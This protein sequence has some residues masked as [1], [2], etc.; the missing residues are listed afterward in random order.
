MNNNKIINEN[1]FDNIIF[2]MAENSI[3]QMCKNAN[4]DISNYDFEFRIINNLEEMERNGEF[5][6]F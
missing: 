6:R 4:I 2:E 1:E 5:I 3:R